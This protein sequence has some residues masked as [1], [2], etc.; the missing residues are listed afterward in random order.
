MK[1]ACNVKSSAGATVIVLKLLRSVVSTAAAFPVKWQKK[2]RVMN[3]IVV[4]FS[5]CLC[6]L[7]GKRT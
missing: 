1:Q 7:V 2:N 6:L 3:A 5:C 4:S